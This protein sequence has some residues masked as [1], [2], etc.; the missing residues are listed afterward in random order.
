[1]KLHQPLRLVPLLLV[2]ELPL[3]PSLERPSSGQHH[4]LTP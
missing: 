1:L 3:L 4:L 2:W